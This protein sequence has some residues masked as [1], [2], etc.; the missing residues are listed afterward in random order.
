ILL[1]TVFNEAPAA[2]IRQLLIRAKEAGVRTLET[3]S[4]ILVLPR[5]GEALAM[6][7][8]GQPVETAEEGYE[9]KGEEIQL[10]LHPLGLSGLPLKF[11]NA[12]EDDPNVLRTFISE[13]IGSVREFHRKKLREIVDGA[14]ALLINYKEDQARE[15]IQAASHTL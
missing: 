14:K 4:A 9:L 13:R 5:P 12:A 3:Q 7:D 2:P 15:T 1:C 11:F 6:K 10:K 8:G